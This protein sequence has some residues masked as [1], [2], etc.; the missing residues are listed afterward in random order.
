M[1]ILS[2]AFICSFRETLA[3]H[4][5]VRGCFDR[6]G[7]MLFVFRSIINWFCM[8]SQGLTSTLVSG[9]FSWGEMAEE[10]RG[11]RGSE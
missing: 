11:P 2:R 3:S 8:F 9:I 6:K 5:T 10:I 1:H 7:E 4:N